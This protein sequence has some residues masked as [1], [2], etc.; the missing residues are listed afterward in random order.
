MTEG[1][2]LEDQIAQFH[3]QGYLLLPHLLDPAAFRPLIDEFEAVIDAY[4]RRAHAEGRLQNLYADEPFDRR[5]ASLHAA[6]DDASELWHAVHGKSH[7]TA[8]LFAVFTHPDRFSLFDRAAELQR[9]EGL[10]AGPQPD[11]GIDRLLRLHADEVLDDVER[12][13]THALEKEL[14]GEE[15]PVQR[16]TRQ[17]RA[18]GYRLGHDRRALSNASRVS[19]E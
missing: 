9:I 11:I 5:L 15:C 2:P 16:A 6:L 8:G 17:D 19:A 18:G 7:K 13:A 1:S 10:D 14:P 3:E 4:A 12:R